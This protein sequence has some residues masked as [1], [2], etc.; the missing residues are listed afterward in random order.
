MSKIPVL[1]PN[2]LFDDLCAATAQLDERGR[3][4]TRRDLKVELHETRAQQNRLRAA[5]KNGG[6]GADFGLRDP[7]TGTML[8]VSDP[9]DL[10]RAAE[11]EL[12][13][14]LR[15][16]E[17]QLL[18]LD[19]AA[20]EARAKLVVAQ[21]LEGMAALAMSRLVPTKAVISAAYLNSAWHALA[22][23]ARMQRR[24]DWEHNYLSRINGPVMADTD[25]RGIQ[26]E[27][28]AHTRH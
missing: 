11:T 3:A 27:P 25:L 7:A 16:A 13:G 1:P 28:A 5:I 17:A 20:E 18:A 14:R 10:L 15:L 21:K 4:D 6:A 24:P 8:P 22:E 23:A 2:S 26:P 9:V 19:G 12:R